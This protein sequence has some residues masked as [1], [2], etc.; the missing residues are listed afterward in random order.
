MCAGA[1]VLL[2]L[3]IDVFGF[4]PP[5]PVFAMAPAFA[6]AGLRPSI[7]PPFVL[8]GLGLFLDVL[9]GAPLGLWPLCLLVP[10]GVAF[11]VRPILSGQGFWALGAWYAFTTALGFG[12]GLLLTL[13]V[14]G[15]VPNLLGLGLQWG[16]TVALFPLSRRLIEYFEEADVRFR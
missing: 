14:S 15:Q 16:V 2:A 1:S 13:A 11:T 8:L 7:L 9:W 10:Y 12:A 4:Q 5:E 6:W 3:P